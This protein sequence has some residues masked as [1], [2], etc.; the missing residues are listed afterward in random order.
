M[1][2]KTTLVKLDFRCGFCHIDI[3]CKGSIRFMLLSLDCG[4]EFEQF[5][6]N[7]LICRLE[8]VDQAI[9]FVSKHLKNR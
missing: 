2:Y 1:K 4:A 6:R 9:M 7:W 8:N 5:V 3:L